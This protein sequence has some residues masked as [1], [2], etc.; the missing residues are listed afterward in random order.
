VADLHRPAAM[1]ESS[2]KRQA[3]EMAINEQKWMKSNDPV[4]LYAWAK[5]LTNARLKKVR[6][7]FR[8]YA[9]GCCHQ[10]WSLIP[11]KERV[12]VQTSERYADDWATRAEMKEAQ[13]A[14]R[15]RRAWLCQPISLDG[16]DTDSGR[17]V[18]GVAGVLEGEADDQSAMM[19]K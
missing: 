3:K 15:W 4:R 13:A 5:R 9:C 8:L 11:E 10:I 6:R 14:G 18:P 12:A 17:R 1:L 7:K 2:A 16:E 19:P